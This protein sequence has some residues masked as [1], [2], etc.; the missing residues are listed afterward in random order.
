MR[1][2]DDDDGEHLKVLKNVEAG[3]NY[4]N[5]GQSGITCNV[6]SIM[7]NCIYYDDFVKDGNGMT[8]DMMDTLKNIIN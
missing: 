3:D 5:V 7:Q 6:E 8:I 2:I 1:Y 4:G